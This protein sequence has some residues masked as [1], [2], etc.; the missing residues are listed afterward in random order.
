MQLTRVVIYP[1]KYDVRSKKD[2][3]EWNV[4]KVVTLLMTIGCKLGREK[5]NDT[6]VGMRDILIV[7]KSVD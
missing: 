2:L 6:S 4:C 1:S 3:V 7:I 5:T